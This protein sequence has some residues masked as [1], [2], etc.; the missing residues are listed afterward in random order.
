MARQLAVETGELQPDGAPPLTDQMA[1]WVTV[2]YLVAIRKLAEK[3]AE[4]EVEL[5]VLREFCHDVVALRRGDHSGARLNLERERLE[6]EREKNE[7]EVVA[8]FERWAK[9]PA[10]R[11]WICQAWASPEERQ[12]RLREIFG[13]PPEPEADTPESPP[14][15]PRVK[16]SQTQ[17]NPVKPNPNQNQPDKAICS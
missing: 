15:H 3:S 13:L 4:G 8:Q 11:D 1:V 9:N 6:R 7:A 16:P 12:R 14:S 10:A 17:S 2:R 5:K